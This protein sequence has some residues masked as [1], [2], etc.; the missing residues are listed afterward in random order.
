MDFFIK[1]TNVRGGNRGGKNLFNWDDVR[2]L[3]NRDR[4]SYLGS[5]QALGLMDRGG[6][7]YRR[8]WWTHYNNQVNVYGHKDKLNNRTALLDEKKEIRKKEKEK[9][10][11]FIYGKKKKNNN[12]LSLN[13]NDGESIKEQLS[14]IQSEKNLSTKSENGDLSRPGLGLIKQMNLE[15]EISFDKDKIFEN[16]KKE[17][18][19]LGKKIKNND[20][21]NEKKLMGDDKSSK[22]HSHHHHHHHHKHNHHHNK[23]KNKNKKIKD[24]EN[25]NK[26]KEYSK[27]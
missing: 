24:L 21:Y 2:L 19:F 20:N 8:D 7:W 27:D 18:I 4:Q 3:S 12:N 26:S 6:K 9:L 22:R 14:K 23:S 15:N 11:E 13:L 17:D 1:E 10:Y 5:T 16:K 25:N